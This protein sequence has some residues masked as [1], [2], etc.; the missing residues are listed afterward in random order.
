VG[1]GVIGVLI[2]VTGLSF[3]GVYQ[4]R[5]VRGVDPIIGSGIG[6]LASV[7]AAVVFALTQP[8]HVE[9]PA[10]ALWSMAAMIAFSSLMGMSLY[11]A[12]LRRGGAGQVAMLFA[13][14]PSVSAVLSW[15]LLGDR[16][17]IGVLGGLVLGA[18]ACLLGRATLATPLIARQPQ[19]TCPAGLESVR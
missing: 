19:E 15:V 18:V 12:A 13:V 3:G 7:P 10:Q 9:R 6:I 17:D 8:M 4:Q 11:L 14:I 2:A 16:P 5:Y 1:V